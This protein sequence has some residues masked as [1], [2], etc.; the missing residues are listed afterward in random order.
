ME[1][2]TPRLVISCVWRLV[3]TPARAMERRAFTVLLGP[4]GQPFGDSSGL[5]ATVSWFSRS[6]FVVSVSARGEGDAERPLEREW[7][8][9]LSS[10]SFLFARAP[11]RGH[12]RRR[13]I[14]NSFPSQHRPHRLM[15]GLVLE[16]KKQ[17]NLPIDPR[18]KERRKESKHVA[19]RQIRYSSAIMLDSLS[20]LF[21]PRFKTESG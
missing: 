2:E 18:E 16:G 20:S 4:D 21:L 12:K 9:G 11:T 3:S 13:S 6:S 17:E 19:R 1:T 15:S 7:C 8:C 10:V 14:A 5:S